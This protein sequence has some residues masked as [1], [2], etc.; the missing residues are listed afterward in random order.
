MHRLWDTGHTPFHDCAHKGFVIRDFEHYAQG[1]NY[2]NLD[3]CHSNIIVKTGKV[4]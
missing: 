3:D 1:Q 2:T 4:N